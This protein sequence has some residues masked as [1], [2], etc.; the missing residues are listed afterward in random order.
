MPSIAIDPFKQLKTACV[1]KWI[2]SGSTSSYQSECLSYFKSPNSNSIDIDSF[3]AGCD[4]LMSPHFSRDICQQIFNN[5]DRDRKLDD[6]GNY[7][8]SYTEFIQKFQPMLSSSRRK[9]V[10]N[11]FKSIDTSKQAD[12]SNPVITL[13]DF[14]I[15][16]DISP[17][18]TTNID[19]I[20]EHI[21]T[22]FGSYNV[23]DGIRKISIINGERINDITSIE[24]DY[25]HRVY[26]LLQR[27][28][29][30]VY[31]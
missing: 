7:T 15:R 28:V 13:N 4:S 18:D 11:L 22:V 6:A 1:E 26:Q 16:Y 10:D 31:S 8:I 3:I 24:Q 29:I 23:D 25:I 20:K 27:Y 2:N 19:K 17:N 12:R 5:I 14:M 9:I 30:A 21:T